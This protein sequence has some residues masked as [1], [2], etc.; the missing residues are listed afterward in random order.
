MT[1]KKKS[2]YIQRQEMPS[3]ELSEVPH[4]FNYL[5]SLSVVLV[6]VLTQLHYIMNNAQ[7]PAHTLT[8]IASEL[9]ASFTWCVVLTAILVSLTNLYYSVRHQV[10]PHIHEPT[11]LALCATVGLLSNQLLA[12]A[13]VE[14]ASHVQDNSRSAV[15]FVCICILVITLLVYMFRAHDRC[16]A[17]LK[18]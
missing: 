2:A 12:Y 17:Q 7:P 16:H 3:P 4:A 18:P 10:K 15:M 9:A 11:I 13:P 5:Q 14:R 6:L 8:R 1:M